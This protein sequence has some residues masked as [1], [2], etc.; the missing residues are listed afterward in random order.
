MILSRRT[1]ESVIVLHHRAW[2]RRDMWVRLS[3]IRC[4][5]ISLNTS[6]LDEP[7]AR[8]L[9]A[10]ESSRLGC[11]VADPMR[12]GEAFDRPVDACLA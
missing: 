7:A 4:A 6:K 5:G 2:V 11:P 10:E 12:G 9:I 3:F 8:K 1:A